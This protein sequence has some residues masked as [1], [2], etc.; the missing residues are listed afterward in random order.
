VNLPTI[1]DLTAGVD[2]TSAGSLRWAH[3]P[4]AVD[5]QGWHAENHIF[6]DLVEETK[7][8]VII[9]VGSWKGASAAHLA[10]ASEKYG[11]KIY[12]VDP[13][14][15]VLGDEKGD[16][17]GRDHLGTPTVYN[18]FIR[19]FVGTEAAKRIYPIRNTGFATAQIFAGKGFRADLIYIDGSHEY[20]EAYLDVCSY[21]R[22][23]SPAGIMFGDDINIRGTFAALIRYSTESNQLLDSVDGQFWVLRKAKP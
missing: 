6:D 18:Q 5:L 22:L 8:K 10:A 4:E 9:E 21:D 7:P 11:S 1:A 3:L 14:L 23:L 13:W 2:G 12:C 19:N 15:L 17:G 16:D 20:Q